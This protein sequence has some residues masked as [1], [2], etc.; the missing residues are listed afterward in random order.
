MYNPAHPSEILSVWLNGLGLNVTAAAK[1][2]GISRSTLFRILYCH[3]AISEKM[4]LRLSKALGT[5]P[6]FWLGIQMQH[7]LW[8]ERNKSI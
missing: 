7:N 2:L 4:D 8:K 5:S 1:Y 6:G 3:A